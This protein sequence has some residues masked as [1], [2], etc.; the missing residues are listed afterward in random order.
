MVD[1]LAW[2]VGDAADR[3]VLEVREVLFDIQRGESLSTAKLDGFELLEVGEWGEAADEFGIA[4][5]KR[6]EFG[7]GGKWSEIV[8]MFEAAERKVLEVRQ[9]G[10]RLKVSQLGEGVEMKGAELRQVRK[11][12]DLFE[13]EQT[14]A[15]E[16]LKVC[17][18]FDAFDLFESIALRKRQ[19][20]EVG[21]IDVLEGE[22][23]MFGAMCQGERLDVAPFFL[24][25]RGELIPIIKAYAESGEMVEGLSVEDGFLE[26]V[27][28]GGVAD[29]K[30]AGERPKWIGGF[31]FEGD[32]QF[33]VPSLE[34]GAGVLESEFFF[35]S[36][37]PEREEAA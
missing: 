12:G 10:K 18:L 15:V 19:A 31:D 6:A 30:G 34:V 2:D 24:D 3:H 26:C 8:D 5:K 17:E 21:E 13:V 33:I 11:E 27:G 25:R 32:A 16:G 1:G 7:E 29:I 22:A 20:L 37:A 14:L 28:V 35:V 9:Q 4:E 36:T 23:R